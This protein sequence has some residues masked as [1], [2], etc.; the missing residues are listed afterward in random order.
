MKNEIPAHLSIE[1]K[2]LFI[3]LRDEYGIKD[4]AGLQVLR[5]L[6]ENFDRAEAA[7]RGIEVTG[8]TVTDRWGQVKVSPLCSVERDSRAAF[9]QCLKALEFEIPGKAAQG[10]GRPTAFESYQKG[11]R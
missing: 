10:P 8:M 2:D 3:E 4:T 7:R 9:I 6:C 1:A 11:R 5:K